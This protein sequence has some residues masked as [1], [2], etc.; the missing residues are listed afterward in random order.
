LYVVPSASVVA[1]RVE[2]L[3]QKALAESGF[4]RRLVM[5]A[6]EFVPGLLPTEDKEGR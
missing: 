6:F 5:K 4:C 2:G 3:V 1:D